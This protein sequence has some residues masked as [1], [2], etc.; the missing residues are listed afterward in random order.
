MQ[1]GIQVMNRLI[2][3]SMMVW[4]IGIHMVE[5]KVS[6]A[7]DLNMSVVWT[8]PEKKLPLPSCASEAVRRTLAMITQPN[9]ESAKKFTP[10]SKAEWK[11]WAEYA[12]ESG[13]YGA[14][15]WAKQYG[16]S[17]KKE[18]I[19]GIDVYFLTPGKFA[20]EVAKRLFVF[21]HGGGYVF[22]GGMS[23]LSE[24]ILIANR[25][26]MK[27]AAVDYRMPPD[28]SY[29]TAPEDVIRVYKALLKSYA[30][31]SMAMGGSSSGGGLTLAVV[32]RMKQA[33]LPLPG[34]LFVGT[35]WADLSK[36]GD[37]FYV[38]EGID[39]KLITYD[40]FLL[41]AATLYA[42]G[43]DL[44][45]PGVSPLYGD[46]SDFPPTMLVTGTR[47]L[48]LSLTVRV[49]RKLKAAGSV[50]DLNVYEGLSHVEYFVIPDSPESKDAYST[51][52]KFLQKHLQ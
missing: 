23:G 15:E 11:E 7:S 19:G 40:G 35:P 9:V 32:Q 18:R 45:D 43:R 44:K 26:G 37:S 48:F 38:N 39:R 6:T 22:G 14:K 17:I 2:F 49:H 52:K 10:K 24:G 3:L 47:D 20:P 46:F 29:P 13:T 36:S 8:I 27:V 50:A 5:A 42:N 16:V 34:A 30:P 41:A 1:G 12:Q 28:H 33:H 4:S 31:D 25:T 21:L 51:L